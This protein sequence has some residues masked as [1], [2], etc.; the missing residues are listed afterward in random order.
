MAE[1]AGQPDPAQDPEEQLAAAR[2]VLAAFGG[3]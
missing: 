2:D 3:A 1:A